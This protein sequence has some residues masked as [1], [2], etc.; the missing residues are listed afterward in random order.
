MYYKSEKMKHV[1]LSFQWKKKTNILFLFVLGGQ[2]QKP[3]TWSSRSVFP[4]WLCTPY[5]F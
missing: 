3:L 1:S 4:L 5:H 2:Q